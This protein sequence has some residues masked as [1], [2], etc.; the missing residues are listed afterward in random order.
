MSR[1]Q[2]G[3]SAKPASTCRPWEESQSGRDPVCS[4]SKLVE[5]HA[6]SSDY[7]KFGDAWWPV[8]NIRGLSWIK[9]NNFTILQSRGSCGSRC[10]CH[11]HCCHCPFGDRWYHGEHLANTSSF[12]ANNR[13]STVF[14]TGWKVWTVWRIT[15]WFCSSSP[16]AAIKFNLPTQVDSWLFKLVGFVTV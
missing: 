5:D 12:S 15:Q 13:E 6:N 14:S 9:A 2:F 8:M 1:R 16:R 11:S 3:S 7:K 10:H 4:S